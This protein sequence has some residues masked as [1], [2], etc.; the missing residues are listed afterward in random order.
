VF[1]VQPVELAPPATPERSVAAAATTPAGDERL[2]CAALEL[3][4]ETTIMSTFPK[5]ALALLVAVPLVAV[6]HPPGGG[7]PAT[8]A[9]EALAELKAGNG[10]FVSGKAAHHNQ[11]M[12]RIREVVAGQKPEA[13]VLGCAD[14]RVPPELIFDEGIGDL[15]VVRVAGNVAE[16]ATTGSIEYAAEHLHVPLIV[17]LGHRKC[18]AVKATAEAHGAAEGNLGE[19]VKELEPAVAAARAHPGTRGIVDDAVHENAKLVAGQLVS[20]SKV[21]EHLVHEGKVKIVTAVYDLET[22]KVEWGE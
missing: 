2:Q 21:L 3:A 19:I 15:F 12:Q 8:T 16:P 5:L 18:G 4:P 1:A 9:D 13:V 14:S 20:E 6:A 17:V 22:G 7:K 11:S 10:R